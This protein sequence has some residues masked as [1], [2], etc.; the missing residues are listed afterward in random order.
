M[1]ATV[2]RETMIENLRRAVK[3]AQRA[4]TFG[5]HPFGA[6]LVGPDGDVLLEQGNIDTLHHAESTICHVASTNF[7]TEYLKGCTMYTNFEPCAMCAGSCYWAGI[8]RVVYGMSESR[9][10]EMTGNNDENPTM[11][12]PC[13]VVFDA[14]QR[15]IDVHGP[16]PE[17]EDEISADHLE[18]WKSHG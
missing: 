14:G 11:S 9:L 15:K 12:L 17:L 4:K 13:R 18:F 2:S 16:F 5:K 8:G 3:V 10:L 1:T 7:S 6:I